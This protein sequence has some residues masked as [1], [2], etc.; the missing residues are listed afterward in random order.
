MKLDRYMSIILGFPKTLY[1]N[2]KYFN[3]KD[4]V[5]LPVLISH[6]VYLKSLKGSIAITSNIR[7]KMIQIGFGEVGIFD[8][9]RRRT[10]IDIEGKV[11]F[12]G[13]CTLG[14]GSK[15]FVLG[16]LTIGKNFN[17]NAETSIICAKKITIGDDCL[18]S[19]DNLIMDTDFHYIKQL[20]D[21][22]IVNEDKEIYI[23]NKVWIGCRCTILKGTVIGD[24]CIISAN[25]V[26]RGKYVATNSILSGS[27]CKVVK[28]D[29]YWTR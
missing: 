1:F 28:S 6:R 14:H 11:I 17:I 13:K 9:K 19:W 26:T 12:N 8:F 10:I 4:A 2:F 21:N 3:F 20:E 16:E 29:V 25:S 23:G 15:I 24:G 5:K 7:S 18:F 22:I 27:P